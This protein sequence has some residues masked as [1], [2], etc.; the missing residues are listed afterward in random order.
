[1]S[2]FYEKWMILWAWGIVLFGAVL[3]IFA[4]APLEGPSRLL[5]ELFE[6]PIPDPA[7]QHHRFAIGLMGAVSIGWGLTFLAAFKAAFRLE[8]AAA[9]QVWRALLAAGIVWYVVDNIISVHTGFWMNCISNTAL[10]ILFLIPLL[11][12]GVLKG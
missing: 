7:D 10:T 4:F 12:S 8:G 3:A 9:A 11:R 6:N 1:M 2:A 5:F